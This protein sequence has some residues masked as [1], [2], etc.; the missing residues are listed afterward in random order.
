MSGFC[1]DTLWANGVASA[2]YIFNYKPGP[3][4]SCYDTNA[5][6]SV[7]DTNDEPFGQSW[8]DW[9]D[10]VAIGAR[11]FDGDNDGE[12]NPVDLNNN[13]L[14]D[15]NEDKPA[16]LGNKMAFCVYNDSGPL[17][18]RISFGGIS[19]MG[20]EIRQYL[21]GYYSTEKPYSNV[22][23]VL[24]EIVNNNPDDSSFTDVIFG[25]R[26]DPDVGIDFREDITGCDSDFSAGYIYKMNTPDKISFLVSS[27]SAE[28]PENYFSLFIHCQASGP[29]LGAPDNST[30]CG[31]YNLGRH[32]YGYSINPCDWELGN[33]P[34][35]YDT[36]NDRYWYSVDPVQG[37]GWLN[38]ILTD[39]RMK[40]NVA[41]FDLGYGETKEITATYVIREGDAGLT[42]LTVARETINAVIGNVMKPEDEIIPKPRDYSLSQN[43]P[44]L[45]HPETTIQFSVP[46]RTYL[47]IF[48]T[49][50]WRSCEN[51]IS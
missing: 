47:K 27:Y 21:Y 20:I 37:T 16:L 42:A 7:V 36:I 10:A 41:P 15:I 2:S 39:Q 5:V 14:W 51:V 46:E 33:N 12:Y 19:L 31:N 32:K 29:D 45:F 44:N 49:N 40:I 35:G 25:I 8:I 22:L 17:S 26:G 34:E 13:S 28:N 18:T 30:H 23:F 38:T 1:E 3:V 4:G 11:Y 6:I 48:V 9:A 50:V 24:F 43:F